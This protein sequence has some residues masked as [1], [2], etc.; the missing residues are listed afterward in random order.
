MKKKN[1]KTDKFHTNFTALDISKYY[2]VYKKVHNSGP[3]CDLDII[4]KIH[5][6]YDYTGW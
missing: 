6:C 3:K 1:S 2:R 4:K 5:G